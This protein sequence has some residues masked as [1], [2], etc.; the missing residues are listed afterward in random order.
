MFASSKIQPRLAR[1]ITS[2]PATT[3]PEKRQTGN[4]DD[5]AVYAR[6]FQS[7]LQTHLGKE[8]VG[9]LRPSDR[10]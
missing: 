8:V 9:T 4:D 2:W 7:N 3:M 1:T 6:N 5:D 10:T